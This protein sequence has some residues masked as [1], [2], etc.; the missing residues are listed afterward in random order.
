MDKSVVRSITDDMEKYLDKVLEA[1]QTI[2][3]TRV[4]DIQ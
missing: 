4:T 1:N 3:L 2:N